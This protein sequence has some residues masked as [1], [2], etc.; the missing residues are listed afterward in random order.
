MKKILSHWLQADKGYNTIIIKRLVSMIFLIIGGCNALSETSGQAIS[1]QA[2]PSNTCPDK[3]E[4]SLERKNVK[5]IQLGS[6]AVTESGQI[7][8]GQYLG[9]T[10]DAKS[11]QKLSYQT[12]DN[13]C[14]WVYAPDNQL[15]A[16]KDL[17]Q[18]GRYTV[19]VSLPK[20]ATTFEVELSLDTPQASA[21]IPPTATQESPSPSKQLDAPASERPAADN[22]V[23]NHYISLNNRQYNETWAKLSPKFKKIAGGY[24]EYQQW[25]NSVRE[26]KIGDIQVINQSL[27]LAVV[28]ADLW[29]VMNDKRKIKD[30]KNRIYLIWSNNY[31]SWLFERKSAP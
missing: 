6:Q 5:P 2:D 23:R 14:I 13:I 9:Y 17:S 1:N 7:R 28:D 8:A 27:D 4:G 15:I 31:N 16:T 12:S 30:T 25:W 22:F 18:T 21:S 19:Q 26:I 3:P 29:Y 24:S 10:F 11:G 20:G